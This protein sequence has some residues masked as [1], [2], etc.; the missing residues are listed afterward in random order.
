MGLRFA[1]RGTSLTAWHSYAGNVAGPFGNVVDNPVCLTNAA[2]NIFGSTVINF[3]PTSVTKGLIF[4]GYGNVCAS[5]NNGTFSVLAR[6]VPTASTT[7]SSGFGVFECGNS[8]NAYGFAYRCGI[9][10]TGKGYM[11]LADLAGNLTT[12]AGANNI[13]V[14]NDVPFDIMFTYSGLAT[15]TALKISVDGVLLES[16]TSTNTVTGRVQSMQPNIVIGSI[17]GGPT[18]TKMNLNELLVYDSLEAHEYVAR[19]SFLS[20]PN[21]AGH[22]ITPRG[23]FGRFGS[24]SL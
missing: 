6:L 3:V 17:S 2:A 12:Y 5:S 24:G 21:Y 1:L 19:T 9:N 20:V 15:T 4:P 10:S 11:Q 22:R 16:L 8:R 13:A 18:A 23:G 14:T 7:A